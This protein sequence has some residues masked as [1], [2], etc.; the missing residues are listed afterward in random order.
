MKTQTCTPATNRKIE[1]NRH[2]NIGLERKALRIDEAASIL[3]IGRSSIY[4][5]MRA[6]KLG[7]VRLAGGR[8]R[9]PTTA[10]DAYIEANFIAKD[11]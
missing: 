2:A 1:T 5:L 10:I 8:R 4:A 6:G 9:V 11:A 7:F 3:G